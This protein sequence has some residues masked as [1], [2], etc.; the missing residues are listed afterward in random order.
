[1]IFSDKI[2]KK[3]ARVESDKALRLNSARLPN[4]RNQPRRANSLQRNCQSITMKAMLSRRRL[5]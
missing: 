2:A 1:M 4:A 5:Q 3:N